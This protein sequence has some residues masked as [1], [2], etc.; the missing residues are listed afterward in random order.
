MTMSQQQATAKGESYL[1]MAGFSRQGLIDQLVYE[2]FS[3]VDA[4][5][6]VDQIAP[7]WADYHLEIQL[8]I[9]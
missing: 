1:D 3:E 7:D 9:N 2:G 6:A 5:F 4:T 8:N